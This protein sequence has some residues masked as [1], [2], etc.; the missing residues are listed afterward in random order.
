MSWGLRGSDPAL[1]V[2]RLVKRRGR[3]TRL[4]KGW[5]MAMHIALVASRSRVRYYASRRPESYPRWEW[6]LPKR[7]VLRLGES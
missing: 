5:K 2:Y 1:S 7:Y 4:G 6:P 3:Q